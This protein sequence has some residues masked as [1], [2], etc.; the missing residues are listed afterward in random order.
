VAEVCASPGATVAA[1][2]VLVRLEVR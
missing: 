2:E 1:G